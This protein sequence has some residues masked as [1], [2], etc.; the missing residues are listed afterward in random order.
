MRVSTEG[1]QDTVGVWQADVMTGPK[2]WIYFIYFQKT[3]IDLF[4]DVT[5]LTY[6]YLTS[7]SYAKYGLE[8]KE[9][10]LTL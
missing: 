6:N 10:K 7:H 5:F 2:I 3:R 4:P 8:L 1:I 9:D